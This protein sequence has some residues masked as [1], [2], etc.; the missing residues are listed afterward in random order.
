MAE[1]GRETI[2]LADERERLNKELDGLRDRLR[3][4]EKESGKVPALNQE[5][6]RQKSEIER[7]DEESKRRSDENAELDERVRTLQAELRERDNQI[8]KLSQEV[9]DAEDRAAGNDGAQEALSKKTEELAHA[10][11]QIETLRQQG[12]RLQA[13]ADRFDQLVELGVVNG[14]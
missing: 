7:M 12:D 2:A 8:E 13:K 10:N 1:D 14:V 9:A 6:E 4:S 11:D 3:D 5:I